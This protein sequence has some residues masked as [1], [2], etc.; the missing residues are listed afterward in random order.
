MSHTRTC[1]RGPLGDAPKALPA[2]TSY[3]FSIPV[4]L[5]T[6]LWV[7]SKV[8]GR[9]LSEIWEATRKKTPKFLCQTKWRA[10]YFAGFA[11]LKW[12]RRLAAALTRRL[13]LRLPAKR[14]FF[15]SHNTFHSWSNSVSNH[16]NKW[17]KPQ[18][19]ALSSG[20]LAWGYRTSLAALS[21]SQ[22]NLPSGQCDI[23]TQ[24]KQPRYQ[25]I[26]SPLVLRFVVLKTVVP[27][28][29]V[30]AFIQTPACCQQKAMFLSV[31]VGREVDTL[32]KLRDFPLS[33]KF[34]LNHLL[35]KRKTTLDFHC[36]ENIILFKSV[37]SSQNQLHTDKDEVVDNCKCFNLGLFFTILCL[38]RHHETRGEGWSR[39]PQTSGRG[40]REARWS[41]S[42]IVC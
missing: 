16:N 15:F 9:F 30:F 39:L 1:R 4:A 26:N 2:I 36:K 8:Q 29:S 40:T 17:V 31:K 42:R 23:G 18:G 37:T 41:Q 6:E 7:K 33:L 38:N 20:I 10:R 32:F 3:L 27:V 24:L 12:S 21:W 5:L 28:F 14:T 35:P 22:H 11:T 19:T 13:W 34:L 25:K